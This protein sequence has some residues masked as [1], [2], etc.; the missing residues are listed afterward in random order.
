MDILF[1]DKNQNKTKTKK[2]NKTKR[3]ANQNPKKTNKQQ[4]NKQ[5][6]K[7]KAKKNTQNRQFEKEGATNKSV[8]IRDLHEHNSVT[9]VQKFWRFLFNLTRL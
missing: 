4:T 2:Q 6:N 5:T 7:Q 8:T 9:K 3:T 1:F